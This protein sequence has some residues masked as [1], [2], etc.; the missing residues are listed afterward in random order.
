MQIDIW[1]IRI[2]TTEKE[3]PV[4]IDLSDNTQV[5]FRNSNNNERIESKSSRSPSF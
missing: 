4:L 2:R 3:K 1:D 5:L